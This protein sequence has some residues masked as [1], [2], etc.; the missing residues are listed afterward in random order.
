[1]ATISSHEVSLVRIIG[2][3]WIKENVPNGNSEREEWYSYKGG[4]DKRGRYVFIS[5]YS[6]LETEH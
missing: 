3:E 2:I 4:L 1:M 5:Q 6:T